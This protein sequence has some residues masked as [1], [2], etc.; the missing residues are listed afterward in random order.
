M[1]A[2]RTTANARH[3]PAAVLVAFVVAVFGFLPII[4]WI[5]GGHRA[6]WYAAMADGWGSG[7]AIVL[8]AGL[9]LAIFSRRVE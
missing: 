4:N 2:S 3:S 8:G 1:N 5:L 6:P 9:V 7:S